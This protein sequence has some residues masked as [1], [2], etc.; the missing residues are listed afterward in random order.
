MIVS[1]H[2]GDAKPRVLPVTHLQLFV[3]GLLG[4]MMAAGGGPATT[5]ARLEVEPAEVQAAYRNT[6]P[7]AP[8]VGT[9]LARLHTVAGPW[10]SPR[11]GSLYAGA[12]FSREWELADF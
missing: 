3:Q 1:E 2:T 9:E 7:S 8:A 12:N 5:H 10:G 6:P 11:T 4:S